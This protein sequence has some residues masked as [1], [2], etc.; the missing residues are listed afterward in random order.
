MLL[1]TDYTDCKT[2]LAI[3]LKSTIEE[4]RGDDHILKNSKH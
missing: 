4:N 1:I 2:L 3:D